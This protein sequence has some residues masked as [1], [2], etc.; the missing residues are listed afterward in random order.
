MDSNANFDN[1]NSPARLAGIGGL[2]GPRTTVTAKEAKARRAA[3]TDLICNGV[4]NDELIELM[5]NNFPGITTGE[6]DRIKEKVR[7]SLLTEHDENAPLFKPAAIRRIHKHIVQASSAKQ[8][9]AVANLEAQLSKIQGTESV[10]ETHITVDARL[11]QA[12]LQVLG[13]MSAA[14]VQEL[15][16]EELKRLPKITVQAPSTEDLSSEQHR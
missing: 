15:V 12:T 9:G 11:Q 2:S 4:S 13:T 5:Q 7:A 3:M 8:W 16:S 1:Q 10:S 14:E 6:I